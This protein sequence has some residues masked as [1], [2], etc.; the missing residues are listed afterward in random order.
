LS[1]DQDVREYLQE[2]F[3]RLMARQNWVNGIEAIL[4]QGRSDVVLARIDA[5]VN[6]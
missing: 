1:A 4:E 5:F 6:P 3:A 2:R